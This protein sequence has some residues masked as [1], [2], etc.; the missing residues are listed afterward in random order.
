VQVQTNTQFLPLAR[1]DIR[2][3]DIAL[4]N[5]VLRSGMLIQG[6]YTE[7]LEKAFANYHNVKH[8]IAVSNGTATLHLALKVLG[9]GEGDEVIVPALSYIATANVIELVGATCVFV[10]VDE[11]T[12]NIDV[13]KV[14]ERITSK[15]KA[16][17]PVHEFGLACDIEKVCSIASKHGISVIED[18]ACALGAQQNGKL[19]GTFGVLGSF[20]LHPRKSITSG[21]GG[22]LLTDDDVLATKLRRLRN[23]GIEMENGKM[24]FI[25][26]GFNYRMTDFQAAL[27]WSQFQRLADIL[28][29]KNELAA[30]YFSA[31]NNNE[32]VLPIVPEDR[33]HTWQTFHLLLADELDQQKTIA[34]LKQQNIGT[35]YGAQCIPAQT[36]Y[37]HKYGLDVKALFP[38]AYRAYTKGLAIP[39]Y[40]RLTKDD[41]LY[42]AQTVNQL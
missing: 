13:N 34:L 14:K 33:N 22:I 29:Y 38:N 37:Q 5:E 7:K 32:L 42:I 28:T 31:I 27:A 41:I 2:E 10:D 16:I 12:F 15:T 17:I 21:E 40:E 3:E 18:A 9:I 30:V 11:R 20:S 6:P 4:V 39:I 25:D 36:Y 1:P 8:A 24:N 23:H 26:A 19:V 35:N